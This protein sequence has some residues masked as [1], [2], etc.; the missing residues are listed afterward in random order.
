MHAYAASS[1]VSAV[2]S[3]L[4]MLAYTRPVALCTQVTLSAMFTQLVSALALLQTG[5]T[6]VS[7]PLVSAH[8]G[9]LA[10]YTRAASLA[11]FALFGSCRQ[12][13]RGWIRTKTTAVM[14]VAPFARAALASVTEKHHAA[15]H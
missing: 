1:T 12:T 3:S 15:G 10:L 2:D 6:R 13:E 14:V 11:M 8:A 9:S 4:A 7:A 5:F